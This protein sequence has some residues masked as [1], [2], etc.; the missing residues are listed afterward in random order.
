MR[1]PFLLPLPLPLMLLLTLVFALLLLSGCSSSPSQKAVSVGATRSPDLKLSSP[2]ATSFAGVRQASFSSFDEAGAADDAG[3][4]RGSAGGSV[5]RGDF[6]GRADV[7]RFVARMASKGL[8]RA[9]VV[10]A[11]ER[12]EHD[13][14]IIQYMDK[15][16][17]PA[18]GPTG[19]WTRYRSRHITPAMLD[20]GSAFWTRHAR[21]LDQASRKYG[22]PPEYIVAIIGIE[23]RWGGF[24]G[25]HRIIDALATLAFDYPRRADYFQDELAQYLL[26]AEDQGFD[27]LLPEGSFAGAMGLGQFMPSSW[28]DYAV[29]FDGDGR[30]D[31][32]DPEDAIGSVARYFNAHGWQPGAAV[33]A[34]ASGGAG[35]PWSTD[36]GFKTNY[37]VANLK[38]KGIQ[39]AVVLPDQRQVSLLRLDAAGG[40]EYWVGF[41]N[42]YVITRYNNSTYYAMTVHQLAQALRSRRGLKQPTLR[43]TDQPG[44]GASA[45]PAG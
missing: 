4:A 38:A 27:P 2:Q 21:T 44:S 36:T 41:E 3:A 1:S 25:T 12:A 5:A 39:P 17:R 32:W 8:D 18:S 11:I 37:S 14:S 30:R 40:L 9:Q 16:W 19:A 43:M 33:V 13:P 42:F 20:K 35:L 31:L 29:D 45:A 22:V 7:D 26:M 34:R 15:Q 6:A 23:T 24:M 28:H 10:R